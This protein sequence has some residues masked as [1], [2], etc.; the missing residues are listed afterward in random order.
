MKNLLFDSAVIFLFV[1]ISIHWYRA[2]KWRKSYYT[3]FKL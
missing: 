1:S 3:F 2:H